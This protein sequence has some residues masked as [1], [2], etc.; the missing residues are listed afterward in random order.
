[1]SLENLKLIV[2]DLDYTLWPFWVDTHVSPPFK[3]APDGKVVDS[4]NKHIQCY[5]E[6]PEILKRLYGEGYILAV[7][8]RTSEIQGARQLINLFEWNKYFTYYEIF[9]GS[10]TTHFNRIKSLSGLSYNQMIF[11]DDEER[12][13]RDIKK[14]GVVSILV[15]NG[16]N[17][18]LIEAGKKQFSNGNK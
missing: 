7:A 13:I 6:V 1:M 8:S 18:A 10:K 17:K 14:I 12:N 16:V 4:R 15:K 2:F 5:P 11:F 9:P 3:K